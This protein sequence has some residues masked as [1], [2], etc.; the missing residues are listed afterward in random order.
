MPREGRETLALAHDVV[1]DIYMTIADWHPI[2]RFPEIGLLKL[3]KFD[4]HAKRSIAQ[5]SHEKGE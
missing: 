4:F 3:K 2:S 1:P 5:R